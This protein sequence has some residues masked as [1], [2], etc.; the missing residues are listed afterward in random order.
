VHGG[1]KMSNVDEAI[2][3]VMEIKKKIDDAG[4][5][6]ATAEGEKSAVLKRLKTEYQISDVKQLSKKMDDAINELEKVEDE[7]VDGAEKL[8]EKYNL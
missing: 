8:K 6:K 1:K 5:R 7:I 2:K 3:R 4:K